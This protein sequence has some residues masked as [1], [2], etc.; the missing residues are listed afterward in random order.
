MTLAWITDLHLNFVERDVREEFYASVRNA[1]P[2][3]VLLGGDIGEAVSVADFLLELGTALGVPVYFV[4]GNHDY[5][6]GSIAGVQA[7]VRNLTGRLVWLPDA[8]V[9]TL[10]DDAVL[11]GHGG[12]ADGRLGDFFGSKVLLNDYVQ[13]AELAACRLERNCLYAELNRLGDEAA[14]HVEKTLRDACAHAH[15]ILL[16]THV[17]PF[18]EA[19]WHKGKL[20]NGDWLP[21]FTCKAMGDAILRTMVAFPDRELLVLCGHTHGSGE[22]QVA[23]NV[24]VRTGGATYGAPEINGLLSV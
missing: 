7:E 17:P 1:R 12:W 22:V 8:R 19:C 13:I 9:V 11:I 6:G 18:R 24:I 5:Y 16:L 15:D 14:D 10:H 23:P 20:S 3:A 21:H 2:D 4:L